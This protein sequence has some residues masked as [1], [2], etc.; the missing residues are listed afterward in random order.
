MPVRAK[1]FNEARFKARSDASV[2]NVPIWIPGKP[3]RIHPDR[4]R[5]WSDVYLS[6][7]GDQWWLIDAEVVEDGQ[8][9][10]PKLWRGDLYEGVLASGKSFV[11]PVTF[12]LD[13][14]HMDWHESLTYAA[15]L[16]RKEWVTAVSDKSKGCF[17]VTPEK[18]KLPEPDGWLD[19]EFGEVIE[20]AFGDHI[21]LS[22]EDAIA[23]LPRKSRRTVR[24]EEFEE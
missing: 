24:E 22:K 21:I 8:V 23:K 11:L 6:R 12:P 4:E 19:C 15:S 7:A 18:Q 13:G 16:G 10:I 3:F 20:F 5:M 14:I 17:I 9:H 2:L 1:S